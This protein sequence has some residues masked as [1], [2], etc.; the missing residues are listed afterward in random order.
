M[1][2][3]SRVWG[4][5][6]LLGCSRGGGGEC[7]NGSGG[8]GRILILGCG[9]WGGSDFERGQTAA[10]GRERETHCHCL[11]RWLYRCLLESSRRRIGG[12]RRGRGGRPAASCLGNTHELQASRGK[13]NRSNDSHLGARFAVLYHHPPTTSLRNENVKNESILGGERCCGVY[14]TRIMRRDISFA[15]DRNT[16]IG[17]F[18]GPGYLCPCEVGFREVCIFL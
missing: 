5:C 13:Y 18:L 16:W 9:P 17:G 2:Q 8:V 3:G 10:V 11:I 6:R 15:L 12:R 7:Q 4:V 14:C 1:F